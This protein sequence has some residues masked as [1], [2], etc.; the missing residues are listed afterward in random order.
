MRIVVVAVEANALCDERKHVCKDGS[1][2]VRGKSRSRGKSQSRATAL[3]SQIA[4]AIRAIKRMQS[5][6]N[7][8][9][10]S[11]QQSFALP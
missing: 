4:T 7:F 5:G 6:V 8:I 2:R 11:G 1:S 10:L 3:R 9:E